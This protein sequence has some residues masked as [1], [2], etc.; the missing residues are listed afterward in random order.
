[1]SKKIWDYRVSNSIHR[2]FL[3]LP[4]AQALRLQKRIASLCRS[5]GFIY[6]DKDGRPSLIPLMLRPRLLTAAQRDRL[7]GIC[8]TMNRAYEKAARA[9]L[10]NPA[11]REIFP[12]DEDEKKWVL[13][14]LSAVGGGA[15]PIFSR[16]DA[17][18]SFHGKDWV[19]DF[20]F[21]ENNGVG[22]G[23]VWYCPV[24]EE[25]MLASVVPELARLDPRL[26]LE[27]NHDARL[28]LMKFLQRHAQAIGRRDPLVALAIDR[29]CF[30]NFIEFPRIQR[31]FE[32]RGLRTIVADPRRFELSGRDVI[33]RGRKVDLIYRDTTIQEFLA[34][35]KQGADLRGLHQAFRNNQVVSSMGGEF[36]H[37]SLFEFFT[38][39]V[40]SRYFTAAEKK[41]FARHVLWTRLVREVKTEVPGGRK[42]DLV[43]FIRR[44]KESLVLKPN[45]LFGGE[46]VLIGRKATR[47]EWEKSLEEGLSK[48]GEWVVQSHGTVYQKR[49]P[50][51]AA[52]GRSRDDLYY[53][54]SGFIS[55]PDGLAIL[56][57]VSKRKVVNVARQGGISAV[58]V[59]NS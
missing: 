49:F 12:F 54:V 38:N 48:P 10:E 47:A 40:F 30:E 22:I 16:W 1:M 44:N 6:E 29:S 56:G 46:G 51:P 5:K 8:Q 53:V 11:V 13:D 55:T 23:G 41:L 33:Y 52:N 17:N 35:E 59:S 36:D 21:F 9:Y 3:D 34:L 57:R 19:E 39:P 50:V 14:T 25:I 24:A 20:L 26:N 15:N 43:P 18:T 37:K 58:L 32:R 7:W 2:L 45:R 4:P 42:A 28:L 31:F 27:R